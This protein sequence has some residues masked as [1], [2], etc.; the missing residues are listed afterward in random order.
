MS[1]EEIEKAKKQFPH[2]FGGDEEWSGDQGYRYILSEDGHVLANLYVAHSSDSD[3]DVIFDNAEKNA[4][5][6]ANSYAYEKALEVIQELVNFHNRDLLSPH[7]QK[8]L[9]DELDDLIIEVLDR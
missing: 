5:L 7:P 9:F 2:S 1:D 6:F 8:E 3:K 4:A